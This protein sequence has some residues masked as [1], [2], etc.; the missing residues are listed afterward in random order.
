MIAAIMETL[1]IVLLSG[2]LVLAAWQ[3][4]KLKSSSQSQDDLKEAFKAL[5]Q[6][7]LEQNNRLFL[8]LAEGRLM[9]ESEKAK[10]ELGK[11]EKAIEHLV[12]PM[13]E[14][15]AKLEKS[16]QSFDKERK[17]DH[18]G[19]MNQL[20][21]LVDSERHLR[22]ETAG[23]RRALKSPTMRGQ[24]G[25]LQLRRVVELAGM[26]NHCDFFEQVHIDK[27]ER[28]VRPDMVVQ[29]P[30]NRTVAIDAKAPL[31]HYL[32]AMESEDEGRREQKLTAYAQSVR[33]H[34]INLG[35][36]GYHE[37]LETSPEFV[38]LFLPSETFFS[39]ALEIDPTLIELGAER[40]VIL[41]T[42]TTLIGLLRAIAH[43]FKQEALSQNAERISELGGELHKRLCDMSGHLSK[44]GRG[45][46][47]TVDAFNKAVGSYETRV[48]VTARKLSEMGAGSKKVCL[49]PVET[50]EKLAKEKSLES[51]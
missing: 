20:K 21:T 15:L 42:P 2:L 46:N 48:L 5:S 50:I 10:G 28:I 9:T 47:T 17:G 23:L 41:S 12:N 6:D 25:E 33:S 29:L 26:V 39:A 35:K 43:G 16:M 24:W 8:S 31:E 3:W 27:G 14:T 37:M 32:E 36:K 49:D 34:I 44:L 1:L 30:G 40:G 11:R 22:M 18:S 4:A 51:E 7:A 19:L 38:V 45:L 13:R